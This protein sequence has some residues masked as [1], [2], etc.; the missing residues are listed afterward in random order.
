M[1][2]RNNSFKSAYQSLISLKTK[3]TPRVGVLVSAHAARIHRLIDF[4]ETHAD[5]TTQRLRLSEVA[6]TVSPDSVHLLPDAKDKVLCLLDKRK[7]ADY[8]ILEDKNDLKKNYL[9]LTDIC[10]VLRDL[11]TDIPIVVVTDAPNEFLTFFGTGA[12]AIIVPSRNEHSLKIKPSALET[13]LLYERNQDE[14]IGTGTF[15]INDAFFENFIQNKEIGD[16]LFAK[17]QY[18]Q[19]FQKYN[20]AISF[21]GKYDEDD[22]LINDFLLLSVYV[23]CAACFM[24]GGSAASDDAFDYLK[25][26]LEELVLQLKE[27]RMARSHKIMLADYEHIV[28]EICDG[29]LSRTEFLLFLQEYTF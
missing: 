27:S 14:A 6:K 18:V 24:F 16:K 26:R 2:N 21:H 3:K 23:R 7:K 28:S 25:E 4:F 11:S 20:A 8:L 17:E 1:K 9:L 22:S 5:C 10:F 13:P 15:L 19:A 29:S 12:T